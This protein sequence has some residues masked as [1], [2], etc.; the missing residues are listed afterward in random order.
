[1]YTITTIYGRVKKSVM[2]LFIFWIFFLLDLEL[3][4][5]GKILVFRLELIA[6]HLLQ[7]CFFFC[8]ESDF[9]K[10]LSREN[11]ADIIEAFNLSLRYLDDLLNIDNI[12]FYQM[13]ERIYPTEFQLNR[14]NSSDTEAP[15]LNLNLCISNGTDSTKI[16]DKRDDFDFDIV[17][18]PFL[19]G[20]VLR[21]TS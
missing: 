13:V 5:I 4:F 11:Q 3:K 1:M 17:K 8:Y 12:N 7:I 18:F 10:S 20:D 15:F 2:P 19:D 14:A 16:Y 9:M 6:L 21:R